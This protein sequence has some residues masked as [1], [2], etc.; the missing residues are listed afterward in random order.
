VRER[1]RERER[2]RDSDRDRET[3]RQ[4]QRQ[5]D[6]RERERRIYRYQ[7]VIDESS[8]FCDFILKKKKNELILNIIT[9]KQYLNKHMKL[10]VILESYYKHKE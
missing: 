7:T 5:R 3:E 1:E 4:R 8:N 10:R 9:M 2:E 6:R